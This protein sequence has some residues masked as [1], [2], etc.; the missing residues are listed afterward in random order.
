MSTNDCYEC[1]SQ[2]KKGLKNCQRCGTPVQSG[3]QAALHNAIK[4]SLG[5][6]NIL[7][8][9]IFA[10]MWLSGSPSI[11]VADTVA[12]NYVQQFLDLKAM[13]PELIGGYVLGNIMLIIGLIACPAPR[14]L[15]PLTL[16]D[17]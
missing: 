10:E 12:Y 9:W 8:I 14:K 1:F 3:T 2:V 16:D 4:W 15:R 13:L 11:N 7:A 17:L 5:V 6:F